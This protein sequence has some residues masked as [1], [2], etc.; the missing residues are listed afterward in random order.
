MFQKTLASTIAERDYYRQQ[1]AGRMDLA[2]TITPDSEDG[3][4]TGQVPANNSY[5][6]SE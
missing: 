3:L 6:M 2:K 1:L 4:Q 5:E